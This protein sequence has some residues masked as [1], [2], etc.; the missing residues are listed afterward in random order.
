MAL[1][2]TKIPPGAIYEVGFVT[3]RRLSGVARRMP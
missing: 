3:L 2:W 1:G